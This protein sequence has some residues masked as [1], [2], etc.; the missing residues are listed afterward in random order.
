MADRPFANGHS[1]I[2]DHE[3]LQ[4]L[5]PTGSNVKM[6]VVLPRLEFPI[7]GSKK[8]HMPCGRHSAVTNWSSHEAHQPWDVEAIDIGLFRLT[9]NLLSKF[10]RQ[11]LIGIQMQLPVVL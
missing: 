4:L 10:R 8:P 7:A 2:V 1:D 3:S 5:G 6:L 9:Q 11:S